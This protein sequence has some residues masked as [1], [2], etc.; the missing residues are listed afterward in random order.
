MIVIDLLRLYLETT[1]FNF[2][3]DAHLEGHEDVARLFEA[4]RAGRFLGYTS[5][6]AL[7]ELRAAPEPKRS[8]MLNLVL[9]YGITVLP[10]TPEVTRL[11]RCYIESGII[12]ASYRFDSA[13]IATASVYELDC[14]ISYNFRHITR[15]KTRFLISD[16][17]QEEGYGRIRLCT[18][19][20]VLDNG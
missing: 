11:A 15:D 6:Y 19:R 18:A 9:Q 17:N 8:N 2:F 16:T 5:G 20:E 4:I 13:H 10:S 12:S 1:V 3:F 7:K 14:V